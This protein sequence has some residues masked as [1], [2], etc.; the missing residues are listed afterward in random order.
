M[1]GHVGADAVAERRFAEV[2]FQHA[3]Q[4]LPLV[5]G[6]GV[7]R[8]HGL[9]LVGDRLLDRVRGAPGVEPHGELLRPVTVQPALPLRI[10][11][12]RSLRR[13]PGRKALVEPEI[14]PPRHGDEIAEPLMRHLMRDDGKDAAPRAVR[15]CRG[16]E[17]QPALEEGDAAP[18]LHGAAEAAG[19]RDQVE[20]GQRIFDTEIVVEPGEQLHRT[21]ERELPLRS[22]AGGGDD[23]DR[24]AVRFRRDTLQFAHRQHEQIGRHFWRSR[25]SDLL[26]VRL[27]RLLFRDR[28]V[29]D[30][31]QMAR[32]HDRQLEARLERRLVPARKY[33][34]RIRRL[35]LARQ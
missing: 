9:A 21:V 35:E 31:E 13:H 3:D 4:R 22:L 27:Q 15:I 17:Q 24:H 33:P 19:H 29:A 12:L 16:I 20:L 8:D 14:V 5:V 23:A 6:N 2:I 7:E 11:L 25:E 26:Q 1:R 28:H 32:D 30:G 18:V 10:K 34:P